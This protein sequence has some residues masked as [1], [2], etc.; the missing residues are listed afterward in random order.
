MIDGE[1]L[2]YTINGNVPEGTLRRECTWEV[3]PSEYVKCTVSWY[4]GETLV[5]QGHDVLV[6]KGLEFGSSIS[7]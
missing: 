3:S 1:P 5:K 6:L 7:L 4:D 2:I